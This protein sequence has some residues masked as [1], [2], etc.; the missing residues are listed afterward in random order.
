[1]NYQ[2]SFGILVIF[3]VWV[4]FATLWWKRRIDVLTKEKSSQLDKKL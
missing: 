4:F 2:A 3:F 1:M